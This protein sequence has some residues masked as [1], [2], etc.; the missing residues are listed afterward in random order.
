MKTENQK[1]RDEKAGIFDLKHSFDAKTGKIVAVGTIHHELDP[2]KVAMSMDS[3]KQ[4]LDDI[5]A[6][7]GAAKLQ[8]KNTPSKLDKNLQHWLDMQAK[9]ALW[10]KRTNLEAQLKSLQDE[11]EVGTDDYLEQFKILEEFKKWKK[12]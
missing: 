3:F 6:Q 5:G 10:Q 1:K 11:Y 8:L 7:I 4:K 2:E 12:K 9:A